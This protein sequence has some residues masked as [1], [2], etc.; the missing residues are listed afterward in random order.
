MAVS[1][2]AQTSSELLLRPS[3]LSFHGELEISPDTL[4]QAASA[5]PVFSW[6][7][8]TPT[9][10]ISIPFSPYGVSRSGVEFHHYWQRA[11]ELEDVSD[12]SDFSLPLALENA[13][14][15]F[16]LKEMGQ[17]PVQFGLR[18]D[19]AR[20]ADIMLQFAKQAGAKIT[21]DTNQETEAD[22][23]IECVVD[24]ESA[25]WRGSRIGLSAPD[26][27]SGAESQVFANAARRACALIG[28]LSDQPAERAEF[29]RLSENEADRIADMRTLLVA[30]DLQ[31]SASPELLR[32]IDVFRACGRIPTED[33][34][35]FLS[36]E[37]LAALRARGVQPR[38]Y[39]RMADRLPEAELLSWLTQLRRQ[40]EQITSAGNPS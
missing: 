3:M 26:D 15:P 4:I 33:F 22:F 32:K 9:G 25:A 13:G 34:E 7:A 28:D 1:G 18:L 39:D 23:V 11:G 12:I 10:A 6:T 8:Q 21:D 35:V 16:N 17:L 40:I 19:Q 36:P 27:L 30:E 29:N 20:Y 31:H 24:V 38:R 37:W 14:R 2:A 5:E